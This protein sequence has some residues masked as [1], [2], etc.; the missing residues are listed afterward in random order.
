MRGSAVVRACAKINLFLEVGERKTDGYH[1]IVTVMQS[2]GLCD[3]VSLT[4][5]SS[6]AASVS[7]ECDDDSVPC[8]KENTAFRAAA[9]FMKATGVPLSVGIS[10]KK[11]IPSQAGL[12]GGSADAAA[13]LSALNRMSGDLL[14]ETELSEAAAN[15]GSD[16]PFCLRG[17]TRLCTGMG[18]ILSEPLSVPR[19]HVVIIK[20]R[21]GVSTKA[22]YSLIDSLPPGRKKRKPSGMLSSLAKG[23]TD[24][25][26]GLLYN[27]FQ[28]VVTDGKDDIATA[29]SLLR[30]T[31][32]CSLLSGSGSSVFGL[33]ADR[34]TAV[35]AA[36]RAAGVF[37]EKSVFLTETTDSSIYYQE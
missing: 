10:I 32:G 37:G 8:G 34:E 36:E 23:N 2:V 18:E 33:T 14:S 21:A 13:V 22:A 16:V 9:E 30:E 5:E 15:V 29:I 11:T 7:I 25:I 19:F 4:A 20:P 31:C 35:A 6:A 24:R 1:D 12:G 26:P 17:G 28:K 3:T 27:I